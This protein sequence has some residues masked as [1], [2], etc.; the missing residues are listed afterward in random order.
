MS[1]IIRATTRVLSSSE[2]SLWRGRVLLQPLRKYR[3]H[4]NSKIGHSRTVPI[5]SNGP[6]LCSNYYMPISS[7]SKTTW[8]NIE[9]DI[10]NNVKSKEKDDVLSGLLG[11]ASGRNHDVLHGL[12]GDASER[13]AVREFRKVRP[14]RSLDLLTHLDYLGRE[15]VQEHAHLFLPL[16]ETQ[17]WVDEARATL[18]GRPPPEEKVKIP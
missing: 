5:Q 3:Q 15:I 12:L 16:Q 9:N 17:S 10:L 8:D 7:R 2:I 11:D 13:N 6:L 1:F 4:S 14:G 18:I